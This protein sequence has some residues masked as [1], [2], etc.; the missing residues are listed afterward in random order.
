MSEFEMYK[1]K[2][3]VIDIFKALRNLKSDEMLPEDGALE[4]FY[5]H[6]QYPGIS[7]F[8]RHGSRVKFFYMDHDDFILE[9]RD[10]IPDWNI[11][12]DKNLV[13]I[14]LNYKINETTALINLVFDIS[15][16]AYRDLLIAVRKTKEI[17]LY[18]LTMIYGRLAFDSYK[19]IKVP[20]KIVDALKVIK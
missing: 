7:L 19:K 20:S 8:L 2:F 3:E 1:P 13:R 12:F 9:V 15:D 18:Y 16:K 11:S 14:S 6:L 10:Q 4:F 17:K 5:Q